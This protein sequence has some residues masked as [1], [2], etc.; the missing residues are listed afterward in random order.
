M[1]AA[2]PADRPIRPP[3]AAPRAMPTPAATLP[4]APPATSPPIAEPRWAVLPEVLLP[5][6]ACQVMRNCSSGLPY[7][8]SVNFLPR[9]VAAIAQSSVW[10]RMLLPLRW[11]RPRTG[12]SQTNQRGSGGAGRNPLNEQKTW[13]DPEHCPHCPFRGLDHLGGN[14][15]APRRRGAAET[16]FATNCRSP[17]ALLRASDAKCE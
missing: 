3:T 7:C 13:S 15:K 17:L 8:A 6:C 1:P 16:H 12:P 5:L 4:P 10:S 9:I 14:A 2:T 11:R